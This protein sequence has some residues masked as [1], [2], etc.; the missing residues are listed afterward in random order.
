MPVSIKNTNYGESHAAV[1]HHAATTMAPVAVRPAPP[2]P[3]QTPT[4]V[5]AAPHAAAKSEAAKS[6]QQAAD[7]KA[8]APEKAPTAAD[9]LTVFGRHPEGEKSEHWDTDRLESAL[10]KKSEHWD[11]DA[12]Q[13]ASDRAEEDAEASKSKP[14]KKK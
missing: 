10:G 3:Q 8:A 11:T 1:R 2:K 9:E 7:A 12:E 6:R 5:K 13:D 4:A 14:K